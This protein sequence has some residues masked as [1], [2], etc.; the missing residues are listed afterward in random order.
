M[1]AGWL[2]VVLLAFAVLFH[3][4]RA[5]ARGRIALP[6]EVVTLTP[7]EGGL[8][9]TFSIANSGD[10]PLIVS[11]IAI[12]GDE[13]DVRSPARVSVR[14]VDGGVAATLAPGQ[15]KVVSVRFMPDRD[16]RVREARGH[17]VV[18]STDERAGE[19]A[20]GFVAHVPGPLA[21]LATHALT[22]LVLVPLLGVLA[23]LL[24]H[25]GRPSRDAHGDRSAHAARVVAFIVVAAEAALALFV[26]ARFSSDVTRADGNDGYQLIE[27]VVWIR[28]LG[29]EYFVGID[30]VSI[31]MVM[32]TAIVALVGVVA[33]FRIERNVA[34]YFAAYFLFVAGAMGTFVAL[35][36]VLFLAFLQAAL[37][38]A[39]F[40][41]GRWG[42]AGRE[43]AAIKLALS[44]AVAAA[45]LVIAFALLSQ[46]ADRGFLVDGTPVAKSWAIPDLMRVAWASKSATVLGVPVW[47]CAWVLVVVAFTIACAAFPLHTWLGDA[48]AA[49]PT[50]VAILVCGP[51]LALG[52]YGVARIALGVLPDASRWGGSALAAFGAVTIVY[53]A[54]CA[55]AQTDLKRVVAYV[56]MSHMGFC[57]LGLGAATPQGIA[58]ALTQLFVHGVSIAMLLVLIGALEDRAGTRDV[59]ALEGASSRMPGLAL[60]LAIAMLASMGV[61][62]LAGFWGA[63]L[64]VLGAFPSHRALAAV[65]VAGMVLLA[66]AHW[67]PLRRLCFSPARAS[68]SEGEEPPALA[69]L[70]A[71]DVAC[72]L[73]LAV[74]V[75]VLGVWPVPLLGVIAG[76]VRDLVILVSPAGPDPIAMTARAA[77]VLAA[78]AI[79]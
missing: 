4:S 24:L 45:L 12:R 32:L 42:G 52:P 34:A 8:V 57:L 55:I 61:P 41:V 39:C 40:L 16:P 22:W 7:A 49:A 72:V 38:A 54:L 76:G 74:L 36:L 31:A 47:R 15:S 30:G 43:R 50:P 13:Q 68:A 5:S 14:F 20:V 48:V 71:R 64:P 62:G 69:S 77:V 63:L 28:P 75:V 59:V 2:V 53:G 51:M 27:R 1:R 66:A 6:R 78:A 17:V 29:A 70:D 18:T 35:D 11:R 73:P 65:A 19:V 21:F 79:P 37:V 46:N 33:S 60:P 44:F 25:L 9:G 56:S 58:G 3:A 67:L 26:Y 10:E 23:T